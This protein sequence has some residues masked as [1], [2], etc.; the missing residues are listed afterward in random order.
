[1]G[2][3]FA[4]RSHTSSLRSLY[5]YVCVCGVYGCHKYNLHESEAEPVPEKKL[6]RSVNLVD[7]PPPKSPKHEDPSESASPKS[8]SLTHFPQASVIQVI[9]AS[10]EHKIPKFMSGNI[11]H[12]NSLKMKDPIT[13]LMAE[14]EDN[15]DSI[16]LS[17]DL[18]TAY[19]GHAHD[20]YIIA[21]ALLVV[22][23]KCNEQPHHLIGTLSARPGHL[24]VIPKVTVPSHK[25]LAVGNYTL[26]T[27][28]VQT[29]KPSQ[30]LNDN[31]RLINYLHSTP[32][33]S[34]WKVTNEKTT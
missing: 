12:F 32:S 33:M 9:D 13:A 17:C 18:M 2:P 19:P 28:D 8:V 3:Q 24:S 11:S 15:D 29:L 34:G 4:V 6:K 7:R 25:P 1:M 16:S 5:M 10:S 27:A 14:S 22:S 30:W 20:T 31:V 23:A 21:A 26:T